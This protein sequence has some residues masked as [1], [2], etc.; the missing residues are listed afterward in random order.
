MT[1]HLQDRIHSVYDNSKSLGATISAIVII[2]AVVFPTS[3]SRVHDNRLP[4][5]IN[6]GLGVFQ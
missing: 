6:V 3:I 5:E 4:G 2:D 1:M